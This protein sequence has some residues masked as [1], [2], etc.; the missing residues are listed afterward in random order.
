VWDHVG[1]IAI[2]L[3]HTDKEVMLACL[4]AGQQA[5][6]FAKSSKSNPVAPGQFRPRGLAFVPMQDDSVFGSSLHSSLPTPRSL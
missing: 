4:S 5:A 6:T 2:I 1:E 3:E